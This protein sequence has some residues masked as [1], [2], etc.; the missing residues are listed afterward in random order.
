MSQYISISLIIA[1]SIQYFYLPWISE[2]KHSLYFLATNA[3][4][5]FIFSFVSWLLISIPKQSLPVFYFPQIS[6]ISA[7]IIFTVF[8]AMNARIFFIFPFGPWFLIS[9][10]NRV[11]RFFYFP[12]ISQ[13]FAEIIFTVFLAT[14]TR[15]F[16]SSLLFPGS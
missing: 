10:P 1:N 7:E 3:R 6:Q 11:D 16:L 2:K 5:F 9:I 4:I 14:N 13:I 12:Q 8:L 15:I